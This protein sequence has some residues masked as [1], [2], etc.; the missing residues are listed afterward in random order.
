MT[1]TEFALCEFGQR[2]RNSATPISVN[3]PQLGLEYE[4]PRDKMAPLWKL[5]AFNQWATRLAVIFL[6]E[7]TR[8][9]K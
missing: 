4:Y 9:R 8:C 3:V 7:T 5:E 6:S 2:H 1:L